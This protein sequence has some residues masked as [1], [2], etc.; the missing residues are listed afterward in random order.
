M[1]AE[2]TQPHQKEKEKT[3]LEKLRPLNLAQSSKQEQ[4]R[5]EFKEGQSLFLRYCPCQHILLAH[6][7]PIQTKNTTAEISLELHLHAVIGF[8]KNVK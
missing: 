5:S 7:K 3:S 1:R 8:N 4:E 2:K 6:E